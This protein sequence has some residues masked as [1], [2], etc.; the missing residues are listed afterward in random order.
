[1]YVFLISPMHITCSIHLIIFDLI[2]LIK[3]GEEYKL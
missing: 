3:Y 2:T 1:M